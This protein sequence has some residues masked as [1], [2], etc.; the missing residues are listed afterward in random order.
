MP[1]HPIACN[2][3]GAQQ[4]LRFPV[5]HADPGGMIDRNNPLACGLQHSTAFL[6]QLGDVRWLHAEH[7]LLDFP[8]QD[9][10]SCRSKYGTG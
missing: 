8:G 3:G 10:R 5:D 9:H 6:Q 2:P 7:H 4:A 1:G